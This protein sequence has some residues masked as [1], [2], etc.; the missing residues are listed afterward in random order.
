MGAPAASLGHVSSL[1]PRR[2]SS[3]RFH[4]SEMSFKFCASITGR[5]A[6]LRA[7]SAYAP[8]LGMGRRRMALEYACANARGR[9]PLAL[10]G[11]PFICQTIGIKTKNRWATVR[12]VGGHPVQ[13]VTAFCRALR[14]PNFAWSTPTVARPD[15]LS[16]PQPRGNFYRQ[17]FRFRGF[18][19]VRSETGR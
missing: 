10:D 9:S 11:A 19:V 15:V 14:R 1:S 5:A 13:I 12:R 2:P 16:P 6:G 8:G 18:K 3:C 17:S 4:C 7:S